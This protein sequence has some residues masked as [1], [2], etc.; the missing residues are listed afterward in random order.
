MKLANNKILITGGASGIGLGLT[1]RFI[2]ENNTVIICGRRESLL[3]EVAAKFPAVI[4]RVCDLAKATDRLDLFNWIEENHADLNV[5]VNNAGIQNWVNV[6]DGNLFDKAANEIE[7]NITAPV[8]LANLFL[9]L[10]SLDTIMNV[11]SGLAFVPLSKVPVYSATKAFLR[12]FTL[13]LRHQLKDKNIEVIEIIPPAL[14]TDLGGKGLHDE[15]PSVSDFIESIFKQLEAGKNELTFGTSEA[16]AEANN[17][18]ILKYFKLMN[19]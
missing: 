19:P 12:S 6:S 5:L 10:N 2:Q 14:N 17:E 1:E 7:I 18:A 15:H 16:R 11:T 9:Q 8:H 4:T 13:S 3:K